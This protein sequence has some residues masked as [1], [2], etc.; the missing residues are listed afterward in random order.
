MTYKNLLPT[1]LYGMALTLG[2]FSATAQP[3]NATTITPSTIPSADP[4]ARGAL[5]LVPYPREVK[6]QTHDFS[7]GQKTTIVV[8]SHDKEDVN[9]ASTLTDDM[10]SSAN[11]NTKSG[12]KKIDGA[13]ILTRPGLDKTADKRLK[14]AGLEIDSTFDSEGYIL[15]ADA[16]GVIVSAPTASGLFYG[17]Q[18]LRQ[19]LFHSANGLFIKGVAIRDW[20]AM[21][22]RWQQDDWA[23]GPIPSLEYAKQQIRILSEYKMNGYCI[24][25][26]NNYESTLH[27]VINPYGGTLSAA[28]MKELVAYG[29]IYHVEV[30]PQQQTFGHLHYVLRQE[31]YSDLGEKRGSQILSPTEEGSY[32]FVNDYLSEVIPMFDSPFVHIG[33]DETFELGR[34][35]SKELVANSSHAD[36]YLSYLKRIAALA[37]LKDKKL[38]FWGDIALSDP[39]KLDQLPKNMIAVAWDYLARE[40]YSIFLKPFADR[41]I[42]TFVAPAAFYGG[43]VFPDYLSHMNNIRDFVRDG[44]KYGS[45]GMLNTSWDDLGEDLFD[46]G[47]YGVVF[48][49]ACAWQSG[50]SSIERYADAFD[51][52]FYRNAA[53]HAYAEGINKLASVHGTVGAVN[54]EMA[55]SSPFSE[56]GVAQQNQLQRSG[57]CRPMRRLC[58]QAYTLFAQARPHVG[59]HNQTINA[60]LFAARRLDFVFH[61]ALLASEMSD[62][63]DAFVRDD[64]KGYAVN[65]ALYDLIMPYASRLG[66]LRDMTKELKTFHHDLWQ[67]ENRPYHWD[68][69]GIRYDRMLLEWEQENNRIQLDLQQLGSGSH[70]PREKVGFAFER[71]SADS[72]SA[73]APT[74][75]GTTSPS[76][77]TPKE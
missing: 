18:T 13:I 28:E 9:A 12:A 2:I 54:F 58:E 21:R 59:L 42:P 67:Y 56:V 47:W 7:I 75:S 34:G 30:I 65:T 36:V 8:R 3:T 24:Y 77:P 50:E 53:N 17:V 5:P 25:A 27:P 64:D 11:L 48:S 46:M 76:A 22:Y 72:T 70:L 55:Y 23:R 37:P 41:H 51:W 38:L 32:Q 52:A 35:K 31:L 62:L 40:N 69:V 73:A 49:G 61:K 15:L 20:P 29:K 74:P 4:F 57:Q 43:R 6:L 19:L 66:S 60:L 45:I 63:Y 68:V 39:Q 16:R 1:L 10:T 14:D 33:C 71:P 44:Q 26:E